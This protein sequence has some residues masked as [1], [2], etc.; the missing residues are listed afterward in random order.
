MAFLLPVSGLFS[1]VTGKAACH[2]QIPVICR[3]D[4]LGISTVVDT[5]DAMTKP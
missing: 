5:L 1:F 4:G 2:H 3:P